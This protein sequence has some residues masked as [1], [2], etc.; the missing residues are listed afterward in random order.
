MERTTILGTDV[1][2]TRVALGTWAIGGWM[3]GGS[4]DKE[5]I[6]TIREALDSGINTI[7]TAPAYGQG[8]AE[9]VVGQALK[10]YGRRSDVVV[11]TKVCLDWV[12]TDVFRNGSKERIRKEIDDSLARLGTDYIDIYQVHWPDPLVPIEETAEAMGALY[13]EGK[14]RAIGVSNFTARQMEAFRKVAPIHTVQPPYNLFERDVERD[15][16]PYSLGHGIVALC[17]GSLCRGLLS[18]KMTEDRQFTGDDLRLADPKFQA[19]HFAHYLA[20]VHDLEKLAQERYG[21]SV[22]A[23]AVRWILDRTKNGIA[24]WG[25]RHPDQIAAAAEV[26]DFNLDDQALKDIDN[27][28]DKNIKEP[29][30]TEFMAPPTRKEYEQQH[31]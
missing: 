25:A 10:E 8:H 21:K 15:V 30:G 2:P 11:A 19:P 16:L 28:L 4:D 20:A 18:G 24:L 17:Y 9:K 13:K 27:I 29:I 23:L 1:Q 7:D 5:S 6:R 22:R 12:G 3:W 14:I 26:A 31:S